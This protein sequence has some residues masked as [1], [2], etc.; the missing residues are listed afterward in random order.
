MAKFKTLITITSVQLFLF[1]F[2]DLKSGHAAFAVGRA[3]GCLNEGSRCCNYTIL[4]TRTFWFM[5]R[6][7]WGG[8]KKRHIL[9]LFNQP[10][11]WLLAMHLR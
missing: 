11:A 1:H 9:D 4:G 5:P 6:W 10:V 2:V 8:K 7:G 3:A